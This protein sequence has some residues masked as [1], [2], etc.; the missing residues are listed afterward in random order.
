[1]LIIILGT[2]AYLVIAGITTA[3]LENTITEDGNRIALGFIWPISVPLISLLAIVMTIMCGAE[4][5]TNYI[6]KKLTK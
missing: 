3:I 5:L 6:I 4:Q 1:M 2:L